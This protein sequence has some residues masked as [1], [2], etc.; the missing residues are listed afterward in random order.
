MCSPDAATAELVGRDP[1]LFLRHHPD[2][3]WFDEGHRVPGIFP[4]LRVAVD[5]DR[6]PGRFVLSGS[7]SGALTR[8][9]SVSLAG[10]AGILYL[11]PFTTAELAERE[12]LPFLWFKIE[13]FF[14]NTGKRLTKTPKGWIADAGLLHALL[15]LRGPVDL[16]DHPI[17]G[18]SWEGWILQELLAQSSLLDSGPRF[19]F[20][21]TRPAQRPTSCSRS[22]ADSSPSRSSTPRGSIPTTS[23]A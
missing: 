14:V 20:Y 21:R 22:E 18:A 12:P 8:D 2:R 9:V 3:V 5:R 13:P 11:R 1:A 16:E 10:R 23:A 15:D 6:R 17:L 7:A 19:L 4:A